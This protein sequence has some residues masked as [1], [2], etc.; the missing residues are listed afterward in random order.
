MLFRY[1][2]RPGRRDDPMTCTAHSLGN[3]VRAVAYGAT[4]TAALVLCILAPPAP[5]W[6]LLFPASVYGSVFTVAILLDL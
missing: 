3:V 4:M 6:G 1:G 5:V 2:I